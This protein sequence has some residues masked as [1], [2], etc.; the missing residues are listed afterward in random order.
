MVSRDFCAARNDEFGE[1]RVNGAERPPSRRLVI[2]H[3]NARA[4]KKPAGAYAD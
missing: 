3:G 4:M 1:T 2:S